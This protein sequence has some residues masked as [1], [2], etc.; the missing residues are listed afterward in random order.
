LE[1]LFRARTASTVKA[2]ITS[3]QDSYVPKHARFSIEVKRTGL[4]VG[5][6][7]PDEFLFDDTG[8]R[9]FWPMACADY[10]DLVA[11]AAMRDQLWA[12]AVAIYTAAKTCAACNGPAR[13]AD[14]RWWL[15]K[16][17][18]ALLSPIHGKYEVSDAWANPVLEYVNGRDAI[19]IQEVLAKALMIEMGRWT[20]REVKRVCRVL[21]A[22]GE[23]KADPNKVK[24]KPRLWVR[25]GGNSG[26]ENVK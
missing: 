23:W 14:H 10:I 2:F 18:E 20:D 12:E 13:C 25:S 17:E 4:V 19:S 9:R 22:S 8:H 5:T 26:A 6:L 24:G 1:T 21:K 11:L 15:G 16:D 3:A 7:N